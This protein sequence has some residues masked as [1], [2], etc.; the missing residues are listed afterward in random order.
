MDWTLANT[1]D[2]DRTLPTFVE[3]KMAESMETMLLSGAQ[4]VMRASRWDERLAD[5]A[6]AVAQ[7]YST[8]TARATLGERFFSLERVNSNE[9]DE[10]TISPH[11]NYMSVLSAVTQSNSSA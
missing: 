1:L 9:E 11:Q 10:T 5:A 2:R 4:Q 6:L 7:A 8:W 3:L